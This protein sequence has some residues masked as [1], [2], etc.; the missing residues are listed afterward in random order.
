MLLAE[1]FRAMARDALRGRWPGAAGVALLAAFLGATMV[2]GASFN[3]NV[4]QKDVEL[5]R[6]PFGVY[7]LLAA[8]GTVRKK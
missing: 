2:D 5:F 4:G 7:L 6:R 3:F 1:D 8:V